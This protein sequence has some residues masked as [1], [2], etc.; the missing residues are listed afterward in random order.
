M[1][2]VEKTV[3]NPQP[4]TMNVPGYCD[5]ICTDCLTNDF[6]KGYEFKPGVRPQVKCED[7]MIPTA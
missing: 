6:L 3:Y 5:G 2:S 1:D 4:R 7:R